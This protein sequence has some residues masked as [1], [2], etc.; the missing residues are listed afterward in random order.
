MAE[1]NILDNSE[2]FKFLNIDQDILYFDS[3][4]Q[5]E[6]YIGT[7]AS[8]ALAVAQEFPPPLPGV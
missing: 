7:C 3:L 1:Q 5:S 4:H 6:M 2:T 8:D